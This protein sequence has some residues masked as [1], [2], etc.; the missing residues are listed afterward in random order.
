[1]KSRY[2]SS[3]AERDPG[4][5]DIAAAPV[6]LLRQAA[7]SGVHPPADRGL[8]EFDRPRRAAPPGRRGGHRAAGNLRR[9]VRA[10]RVADARISRPADHEATL[11]QAV[12][13]LA[14]AIPETPG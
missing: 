11:A 8:Q 13:P 2:T 10:D 12:P 7:L 3:H 1:M 6:A 5:A 14:P 9:S 4:S